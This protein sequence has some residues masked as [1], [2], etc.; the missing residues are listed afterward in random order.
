LGTKTIIAG[1]RTLKFPE[2]IQDA[3]DNCGWT[4]T[5]VVSGNAPGIDQMG[6]M[7]AAVN[8]LPIKRFPANW[9]KFGKTAGRRRNVEMAKYADA[10][11]AI[12]DGKSPG[13]KHMIKAAEAYNLR[14]YV[15]HQ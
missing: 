2:L 1:T 3:V 9:N 12:W 10:L 8:H 5:E 15:A 6:E 14:I 7:W 13:T 11:I 4:I